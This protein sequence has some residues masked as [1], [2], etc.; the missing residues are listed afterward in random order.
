MSLQTY[1]AIVRVVFDC[2]LNVVTAKVTK[3][4]S[5][6]PAAAALYAEIKNRMTEL[7]EFEKVISITIKLHTLLPYAHHQHSY[8]LLILST[9]LSVRNTALS[10]SNFVT[11]FRG[12]SGSTIP[13]TTKRT[14]DF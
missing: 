3:L 11:P 9:Y 1:F 12:S 13:V 5:Q 6:K 14:V 7:V 8:C 10:R 4:D 2:R